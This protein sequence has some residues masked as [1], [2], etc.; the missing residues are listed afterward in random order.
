MW[1]NLLYL[2]VLNLGYILIFALFFY[3]P[4]NF[5]RS[6]PLFASLSFFFAG[7][8]LLFAYS[9]A[10]SGMVAVLADFLKPDFKDFLK[11]F[12]S[13]LASSLIFVLINIVIFFLLSYAF[14]VYKSMKSFIGLLASGFLF[15]ILVLWLLA[16]LYFFPIQSRLDKSIIKIL[17]KTLLIFIDNPL[18]TLGLFLGVFFIFLISILTA[19]LLPGISTILLWLNVG[20]K[21]RLYKYDYLDKNPEEGRRI[22]WD[23]LLLQDREKVGKRT[24]KGMIF[25]WKE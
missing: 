16:F 24:L 6:L 4:L 14:P 3:L 12:K 15:W 11:S 22:P 25:P 1:D 17:K 21:L 5:F 10:V 13:S 19:F 23:V 8:L 20:L 7:L 2:V 18:F 9:G